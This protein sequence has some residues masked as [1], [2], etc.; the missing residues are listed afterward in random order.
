MPQSLEFPIKCL[1]SLS[2]RACFELD[3]E[4]ACSS[5][6]DGFSLRL[7][8]WLMR[9]AKLGDR[10][11]PFS[12]VGSVV[13]AWGRMI[14]TIR[15]GRRVRVPHWQCS[16]ASRAWKVERLLGPGEAGGLRW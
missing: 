11:V 3:V 7:L 1:P 4:L 16:A 8:R 12:C 9:R 10:L 6:E 13:P 15:H 14:P 5:E 2:A